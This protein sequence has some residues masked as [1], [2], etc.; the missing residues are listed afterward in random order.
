MNTVLIPNVS[1]RQVNG[2]VRACLMA[3]CVFIALAL[4]GP[5]QAQGG[6]DCID[7]SCKP[8]LH[9]KTLNNSGG[10]VKT[11]Q[12]TERET[13]ED[14]GDIPFSISVDG[15][16]LDRSSTARQGQAAKGPRKPAAKQIDAQRK[17]DIGL[18]AVD[19]Q[20]KFDGLDARPTL[21]ISTMPVRR[22]YRPGEQIDFLATAN[23]P[24][25]ISRSEIRIYGSNDRAGD[26]PRA[27][28]PVVINGKASWTM[29]AEV[30]RLTGKDVEY[31]Y[32]LRVYD[33]NGRFD[34]TAPL[35][36]ARTEKDLSPVLPREA[37]APGMGEDRTALRNIQINGGAVTVYGRRVPAGHQVRALGEIIPVDPDNA[38]IVQR[39]L[40]PGEH[41]VD[42][43][44][45]KQGDGKDSALDFR[46]QINIPNNDWFY[47]ALADFTVGKRTGDD[48]IEDVR[49]GEYDKI[50][51]KGRLAYYLK[52]KIKGKYLLT[53]AGDTGEAPIDEM[54]RNLDA[55]DPRSLLRRLDPDDYYPV[56]GDDSTAI[57]DAPTKGKFYVR[58]ERGDSQ[59]MWGSYKTTINGTEF[60]RSDR[61]LYGANGVYRSAQTTSFGE[62]KTEATLYA[63]QP[64]TLPQRDEFLGSGSFYW[65]KRQDI[66]AGSETIAIEVRDAVTG[67]LIER[68]TLRYGE[69]YSFDYMQ[70]TLLLKRPVLS[71]AGTSGPVRDGALGGNKAYV[72]AQYEYTPVAGDVDGYVYGGRGQHWINDKVRIGVTGMNET[73][74]DADQRALGADIK[75]RHSDKT[76]LEAE[77]ANSKGPGFGRSRSLDGGLT[78]EDLPSSGQ[79]NKSAMAYRVR[80]QVGLEDVF[81]NGPKGTVGGYF[82][83]TEDGFSTLS[84]Q[85][86]GDERIWGAFA[87][88]DVNDAVTVDLKYDDFRAADYNRYVYPIGDPEAPARIRTKR[89]GEGAVSWQMDEYWKVTFGITYTELNDPLRAR[90]SRYRSG[91]NGDR[92]DAGMRVEYRPN[93][94]QMFYGFGQGTLSRSGDIRRNDRIGVGTELKLTEK[95]GLD[96]EVSYGT[97]GLGGLA[98]V[99]Y[100]PTADDQY[101]I[102][103]RLD[104]GRAFDLDRSYDLIGTDRG[105]IVAGVKHR[106]GDEVSVYSEDSYDMF[107]SRRS[108][109]QTYGVIYTPDTLWTVNASFEA[110]LIEDDGV[111]AVLDDDGK[112]TGTYE[113]REN[114]DRKAV[115]VSVGYNN[116]DEGITGRVRGEA[117]FDDSDDNT[118]DQNTYLLAAGLSLK[119]TPDWRMIANFEGVW[120]DAGNCDAGTDAC[121]RSFRD[122]DYVEASLGYAYRPVDN[123]RLNALF[124]YTYLYDLPGS[125]QVSAVTGDQYGP[126]QRSHIMSADFTYDLLPWLS[127]GAKYGFRIGQV[128]YRERS[129]GGGAAFETEWQRSSAHL[130]ILRA[131]LHIVKNWDALVEGRVLS[132]PDQGTVDYGALLAVYRHV[133]EN[134]KVGVGYNFGAFSD[135]LRDQ[136]LDDMGAFLNVVGKF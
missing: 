51:T 32:L 123:D 2:H 13:P 30:D 73:T 14:A 124:K 115:S 84:E 114:I 68:R 49:P 26:E 97:G 122:G 58:L 38:F 8:G 66:T 105:E 27:V 103:Y 36:I 42:V 135:D 5:V 19:I 118:R 31:R 102:G 121:R 6:D 50:Y 104:P 15:E 56:Y 120:S 43:G 108:L 113:Y 75:I 106:L 101:Y 74:G 136:T 99:T 47:V 69:D 33:A 79:R 117:R 76:F 59:V 64:D 86:D 95:V 85:S 70:G 77:V 116:E 67:R 46:R 111:Y 127:V 96:A 110:G 24:A 3:S 23:Y 80:G 131:D 62:R 112:P 78:I 20:V 11:G 72:V 40:P 7:Q 94:D 4:S 57:E 91:Y 100:S 71:T 12:N 44:V 29:P 129:A 109:N 41:D 21:N 63:A 128:R 54:F 87:N 134:F 133:G 25:F 1:A 10:T 81:D 88:I 130:G 126:L 37:T 60:I 35:S 132:M 83:K 52:G 45:V 89:K 61:G 53:A 98:A 90:A 92:L 28:I 9:G 22:A 16:Q 125:D 39:I 119:T 93:D 65:M 17:T 107:G 18:K 82:E 48:H 34:E 55:K